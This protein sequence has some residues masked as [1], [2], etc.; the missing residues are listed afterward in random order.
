[1]ISSGL[2]KSHPVEVSTESASNH[3]YCQTAVTCEELS[4]PANGDVDQRGNSPGSEAVYSCV[5]NYVLIGETTRICGN[6]GQWS[7]EEP[8]CDSK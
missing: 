4:D 1:M 8:F 3:N 6:D 5:D 2:E 7:G